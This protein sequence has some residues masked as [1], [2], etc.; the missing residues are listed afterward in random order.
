MRHPQ[1]TLCPQTVRQRITHRTHR[2]LVSASIVSGLVS[3]ALP[4]MAQTANFEIVAQDGQ[5]Q[6]AQLTVPAGVKLRIAL[7]NNG[8][9]PV[10][11]E[12]LP[13]RLEK[14]VRPDSAATVTLLPLLPGSYRITDDLQPGTEPLTVIAR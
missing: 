10:E 6:P 3:V 12:S 13:L 4:A 7:R 9:L 1:E 8:K 5:W 11:F 14:V 2:T